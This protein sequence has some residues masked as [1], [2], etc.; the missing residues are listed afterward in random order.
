MKSRNVLWIM[1]SD[2]I[3]TVSAVRHGADECAGVSVIV[4]FEFDNKK[5]LGHSNEV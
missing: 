1:V 5:G 2:G 4:I 3:G